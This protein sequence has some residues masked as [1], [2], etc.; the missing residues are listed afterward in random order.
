MKKD[1]VKK[2][3]KVYKHKSV[4]KWFPFI[5]PTE[6]EEAIN[7]GCIFSVNI[8]GKIAG[9]VMYGRYKNQN[10]RNLGDRGDVVLKHIVT[11]PEFQGKGVAKKLYKHVEEF[12]KIVK[13]QK[14]VLSVQKKNDR[15]NA[16]YKK[17]GMKIVGK[18]NWNSKKEGVIEGF[19]YTKTI[20]KNKLSL[21]TA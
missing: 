13:A 19:I 9:V 18:R 17:M 11:L 21:L 2:Y 5:R 3:L 6:I 10:K 4:A 15:A 1:L 14:L 8:D 12:A 20:T 7:K 16:F